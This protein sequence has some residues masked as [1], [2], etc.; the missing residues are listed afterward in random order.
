MRF[1]AHAS[2]SSLIL[3]VMLGAPASPAHALLRERI[4]TTSL[5]LPASLEPSI[6]S[7]HLWTQHVLG[8]RLYHE[9]LADGRTLVGWTDSAMNGH[10]SIV[11]STVE[12][13]FDFPAEP[14]RGLVGHANGT[15]AVLLWNRGGAGYQ[16]D[17]MR[18]SKRSATGS[19][20]WSV[21]VTTSEY[22]PN[23][24]QFNIGDSRLA[25]GNGVYGAYL[26]VHSTAGHEGDRYQRVSDAGV[27]LSGGWGWG[28]SHSMAGV[29]AAHPENGALH[30]A[31]VSDCYPSKA[32]L[33][34]KT[35]S[36]FAADAD[37]A[38][39][40]SAQ[41]GQMAAGPGGSW[42]IAMDAIDRPGFPGRGIGIVRVRSGVTPRLVWLTNT[43]GSD[44]RDP[45]LARIGTSVGSNR[46][47]V[48]WRLLTDGS[49][50]IAVIDSNATIQSGPEV[51]SPAV[52]WGA[53]D[54]SYRTRPDGS[55]SWVE[56]TAG[57]RTLRLHRYSESQAV[58]S[59]E[60]EFQP[61][62]AMLAPYP[63]PA[64]G[65][66]TLR[67]R[68]DRPRHVEVRILD[69]AGRVVRQLL[70]DER[71]AGLHELVWNGRGAAGQPVRSGVYFATIESDGD[72]AS[73]A[74]HLIR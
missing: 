15:F 23:P 64:H 29:I 72:R 11:G 21:T 67:F 12:N 71:G 55:I 41:L 20:L 25:Y 13:T 22:T 35:T 24:A 45:V 73:R 40:V 39:K 33:Y 7:F 47:L 31:G 57:S 19:Q 28:L 42:L 54:D 68:L 52:T 58:A 74:L 44:E 62:L 14:V 17:Y 3:V 16:D 70:D 30:T 38:G 49:T 4:A 56:G 61:R 34:D 27:L 1:F 6:F 8:P 18:L 9:P 53:R 37:C 46:Y 51:V 50:R 48:G 65:A 63:N 66:T 2:V 43:T 5:T 59:V 32:L 69:G 10:V 36:L 60:D 26:S